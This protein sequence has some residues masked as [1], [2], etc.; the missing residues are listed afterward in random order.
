MTSDAGAMFAREPF[1]DER[2]LATLSIATRA[3]VALGT[4]VA[5]RSIGGRGPIR[6][7]YL[8]IPPDGAS[9]RTEIAWPVLRMAC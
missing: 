8:N 6:E 3:Y 5:E 9:R 4:H 1:T 2:E 7:R